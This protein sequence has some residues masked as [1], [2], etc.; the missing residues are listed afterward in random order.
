MSWV[1][2]HKMNAKF[3]W[4]LCVSLHRKLATLM[5]CIENMLHSWYQHVVLN[6]QT[7]KLYGNVYI[8]KLCAC[9]HIHTHTHTEDM[10][11][12]ILE[13][14]ITEYPVVKLS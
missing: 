12:G 2:F 4:G 14:G 11:K 10:H 7:L 5:Q 13:S 6:L 9:T 8:C 3:L 1:S